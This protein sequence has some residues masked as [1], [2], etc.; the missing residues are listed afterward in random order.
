MQ[1]DR[2]ALADVG[3]TEQQRI[4]ECRKWFWQR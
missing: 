3:L 2:R 4:A 1:L